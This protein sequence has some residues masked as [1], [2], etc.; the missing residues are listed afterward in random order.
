M[1][2]NDEQP[3]VDVGDIELERLSSY[4]IKAELYIVSLTLSILA[5]SIQF[6]VASETA[7]SLITK[8]QAPGWIIPILQV[9]GWFFLVISGIIG[10]KTLRNVSIK[11]NIRMSKYRSLKRAIASAS[12]FEQL[13]GQVFSSVFE[14]CFSEVSKQNAWLFPIQGY[15]LVLGLL[16]LVFSRILATALI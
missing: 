6:P 4:A 10:I 14:D 12:S 1:S 7:N 5:L 8:L 3:S 9:A 2:K 15:C 13:K 16:F 11:F